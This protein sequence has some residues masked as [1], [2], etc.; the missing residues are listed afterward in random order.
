MNVNELTSLLAETH[1]EL[2]QESWDRNL[3]KMWR[4]PFHAYMKRT[5]YIFVKDNN[6]TYEKLNALKRTPRNVKQHRNTVARFIAAYLPKLSDKLW[7]GK[8]SEDELVAWL[9]KSKLD[10]M[11]MMVDDDKVKKET[12][13]KYRIKIKYQQNMAEGKV[14][15][16]WY[17]GHQRNSWST[18]KG[19]A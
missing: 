1:D 3:I 12:R 2:L 7:E 8:M 9:G 14:D 4:A 13:E 15:R 17:D 19:K 18:I 16:R 10:T 11:L 5:M 6:I